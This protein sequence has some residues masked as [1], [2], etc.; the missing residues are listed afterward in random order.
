MNRFIDPYIADIYKCEKCERV[1]NWA[2]TQHLP[3]GLRGGVRCCPNCLT[4]FVRKFRESDVPA[5]IVLADRYRVSLK[6][7]HVALGG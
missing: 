5:L 1:F 4:E 7:H 2:V 3:N 6:Y